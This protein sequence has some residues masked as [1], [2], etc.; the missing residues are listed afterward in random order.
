M[1]GLQKLKKEDEQLTNPCVSYEEKIP[2]LITVWTS[3]KEAIVNFTAHTRVVD[4]ILEWVQRHTLNLVLHGDWAKQSQ[5]LKNSLHCVVRDFDEILSQHG[6][7]SSSRCKGLIKVIK[8]PWGD[9]ILNKILNGA[10][11]TKDEG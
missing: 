10:G 7:I 9:S 1:L 2:T 3:L 5:T 4:K 6:N 8:D 11:C